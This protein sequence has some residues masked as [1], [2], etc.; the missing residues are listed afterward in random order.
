MEKVS[1]IEKETFDEV[2]LSSTKP[3][4]IDFFAPWCGPC[5]R[6]APTVDEIASDFA[7][8]IEVY[9]VDIDSQP[10]LAQRFETLSVPTL[11]FFRE[12]RVDSRLFGA[13]P[14]NKLSAHIEKLLGG[15]AG[16]HDT[17][18]SNSG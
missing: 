11:V 3:V 12:G 1:Q 14:K 6:L 16:D 10:E 5:K 2:V 9:K 18:S 15:E 8:K 7:G 13:V 17:Q 4:L